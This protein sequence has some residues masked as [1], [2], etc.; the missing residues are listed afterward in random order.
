MLRLH[1]LRLL[2]HFLH[3]LLLL[4]VLIV[5]LLA[6]IHLLLCRSLL[7]LLLFLHTSFGER[8]EVDLSLKTYLH[9]LEAVPSGSGRLFLLFHAERVGLHVCHKEIKVRNDFSSE[10]M[11]VLTDWDHKGGEGVTADNT[12]VIHDV[13]RRNFPVTSD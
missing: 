9:L 7:L 6:T 8:H 10:N 1:H 4:R 12:A 3:L 13:L 11:V 2:V 5:F